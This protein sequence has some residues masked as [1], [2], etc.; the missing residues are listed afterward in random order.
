MIPR[1][2]KIPRAQRPYVLVVGTQTISDPHDTFSFITSIHVF[3]I[4]D[5][6]KG[7]KHMIKGIERQWAPFVDGIGKKKEGEEALEVFRILD[8]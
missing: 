2:L 7:A 8:S 5:L 6:A 4:G 3:I 1:L